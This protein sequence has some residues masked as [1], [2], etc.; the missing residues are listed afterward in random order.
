MSGPQTIAFTET[1]GR[2]LDRLTGL[3]ASTKML[4]RSEDRL[5]DPVAVARETFECLDEAEAFVRRLVDIGAMV[6][7]HVPEVLKQKDAEGRESL[8]TFVVCLD[9]WLVL[10]DAPR[11]P[12]PPFKAEE[13]RAREA[14][15]RKR[16]LRHALV[17]RKTSLER[18][19]ETVAAELAKASAGIDEAE[20]TV[21]EFGE[22]RR[23]LAVITG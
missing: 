22:W 14:I 20:K 10:T 19:L 5:V 15:A 4:D 1:E 13:R 16:E 23:R 2:V 3:I 11:V 17:E 6:P 18:E 7:N 12:D 9:R 21:A 8:L